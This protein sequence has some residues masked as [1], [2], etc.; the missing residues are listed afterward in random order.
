[1]FVFLLGTSGNRYITYYTFLQIL[2]VYADG[3]MALLQHLFKNYMFVMNVKINDC[4]VLNDTNFFNKNLQGQ[5][6][7][8]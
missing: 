1:M 4:R 6:Y 5:L 7:L 2:K 8:L 3:V